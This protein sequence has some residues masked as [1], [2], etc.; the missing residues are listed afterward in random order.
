MS[1]SRLASYEQSAA[2]P[3]RSQSLFEDFPLC[4]NPPHIPVRALGDPDALKALG[5]ED[6]LQ[7]RSLVRAAFLATGYARFHRTLPER[8]DTVVEAAA[9]TVRITDRGRWYV[10][11]VHMREVVGDADANYESKWSTLS[12]GIR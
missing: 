8:L 7:A 1:S 12:F 10:H 4:P 11:F 5:V 6:V 9:A 3:P 2:P